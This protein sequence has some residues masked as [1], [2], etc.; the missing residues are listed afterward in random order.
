V[1]TASQKDSL[2]ITDE[3][4]INLCNLIQSHHANKFIVTHGTDTMMETAAFLKKHIDDKLIVLT[5]S[6]RPERF[7]N[8]DAPINLGCAI[9]TANLMERGVFIAMHGIVKENTEIG[10]NPETGQFY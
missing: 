3:D 1:I 9:A 4:R 6:M 8:S 2:E 7:S 10:R 5:G